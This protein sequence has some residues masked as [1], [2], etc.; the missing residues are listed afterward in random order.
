MVR[1][2]TIDEPIPRYTGLIMRFDFVVYDASDRPRV[3]VEA[4]RRLGTD[5][6]WAA[7]LRRNWLVHGP[8]PEAD[9]FVLVLPD[10]IYIWNTS[11][12][13]DALP[14]DEA[15][16]RPLLSPYFERIGTTPE[17]IDPQAF[18]ILVA[19]WLQDLASKARSGEQPTL[20]PSVL[21]DAVAGGR[22]VPQAAA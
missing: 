11:A 19:W 6:R 10:H 8:L 4:K 9:L 21:L 20:A 18:E 1:A 12:P 7:Q 3:I 17:Q 22:I 5:A 15:D 2:V 16:A 14:T 13:S